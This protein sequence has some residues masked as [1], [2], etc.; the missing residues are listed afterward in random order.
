MNI[1]ICKS[2]LL[3]SEA[4][5]CSRNDPRPWFDPCFQSFLLL[6]EAVLPPLAHF[7]PLLAMA[8]ESPVSC[9]LGWPQSSTAGGAPD[10]ELH[11]WSLARAQPGTDLCSLTRD[12]TPGNG[13]SCVR[14]GSQWMLW[15]DS[16]SRAR[17]GT[18][19]APGNGHGPRAPGAPGQH[20]QAQPGIAGTPLQ[21]QELHSGIPEGLF[22]LRIFCQSES[23]WRRPLSISLIHAG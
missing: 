10:P 9:E 4:N 17:S 6:G 3:L 16:S 13:R 5:A 21:G 22:Q 7:F 14:E 12:R 1:C 11:G 19:T 18:R 15:R 8:Q 20:S 2:F 23:W